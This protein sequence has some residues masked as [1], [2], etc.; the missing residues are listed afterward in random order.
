M[1]GNSRI[2]TW[3]VAIASLSATAAC[4][5]YKGDVERLCAA[6]Q[7]APRTEPPQNVAPPSTP[8]LHQ[9]DR[10]AQAAASTMRTPEGQGLASRLMASDADPGKV[11]D[12]EAK[13]AGV[14]PC[15]LADAYLAERE[16]V[17]FRYDLQQLC[18]FTGP[19]LTGH[20]WLTD[21]A[22]KLD[23]ELATLDPKA[24]AERLS[25]AAKAESF[26]G[27]AMTKTR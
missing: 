20:K 9:L 7:T 2:I 4:N 27:C 23:G 26:V 13:K 5:R 21:R 18:A 1:S 12:A 16:I 25:A 10:A 14:T 24:R 19:E 6:E 22:K 17:R 3:S 11:L 8:H 15:A